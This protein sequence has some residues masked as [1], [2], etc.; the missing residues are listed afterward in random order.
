MIENAARFRPRNWA[1]HLRRHRTELWAQ[2]L[3]RRIRSGAVHPPDGS[4]AA[5]VAGH[6]DRQG[7]LLPEKSAAVELINIL[8]P[9]VAVS[10]FIVF[11]AHALEQ[12]PR[13]RAS[14]RNG[15]DA[16]LEAF[17]QEVRRYYPFF[18]A[19][20]G[21]LREEFSWQG[22]LFPQ[23]QTFFLD[24][25]GTN[26]DPRLWDN[27]ESFQPDRFETW[28]GDP[29]TLVA[30]GGSDANGSHRCPGDKISV[31]LTKKAILLLIQGAYIVPAQDLTFSLSKVPA[32]PR[33]GV[34]LRAAP[35][36]QAH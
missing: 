22:E 3:I 24:L 6:Q 14:L 8:R 21:R 20:A 5:V 16:G 34:M 12:H 18:P 35:G 15:N 1:A 25:Y 23:G 10:R 13:W 36:Q 9:T 29:Y 4:A 2:Q 27:P 19:V 33:S 7:H 11:A 31:E 32:L 17:A 28:T 30:Q 26:H